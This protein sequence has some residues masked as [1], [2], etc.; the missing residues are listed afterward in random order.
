MCSGSEAGSYLRLT[1][2]VYH[3]TLG[4][5]VIK[6]K[7]TST[8][9]AQR[10]LFRSQVQPPQASRNVKRKRRT[11]G[12]REN[13]NGQTIGGHVNIKRRNTSKR[14]GRAQRDERPCPPFFYV[15]INGQTREYKRTFGHKRTD[16]RRTRWPRTTR[17]TS[18]FTVYVNIN[19][20][21]R[22]HKRTS[23]HKR[24]DW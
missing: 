17:C 21:T 7:N 24:T 14:G 1:D 8:S 16:H 12:G 15:Q 23:E 9:H 10:G 19:G 18:V 4:L 6:K 20:Q 13:I 22:E 11:I 3:S 5:R 2:F